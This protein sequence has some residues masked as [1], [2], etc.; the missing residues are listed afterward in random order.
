MYPQD[1]TTKH[2]TLAVENLGGLL[3]KNIGGLAALHSISDRIKIVGG[4][5]FDRLVYIV[6]CQT[7]LLP[8][9]YANQ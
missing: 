1:N 2:K 5:N 7:F 8:K 4:Q 3:S 9:F 6:T